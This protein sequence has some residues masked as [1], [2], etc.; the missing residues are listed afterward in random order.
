[1]ISV[2]QRIRQRARKRK[3]PRGP[4]QRLRDL[5]ATPHTQRENGGYKRKDPKD[6]PHIR[7][8][9]RAAKN[10]ARRRNNGRN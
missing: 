9:A 3:A 5:V 6:N 10:R 4:M 7:H 8:R 1:M 2:G